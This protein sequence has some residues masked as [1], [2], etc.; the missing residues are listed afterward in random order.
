MPHC[1]IEHST[2]LD[3]SITPAV[4]MERVFQ[5]ALASALFDASVIKTRTLA[6]DYFQCGGEPVAFIHVSIRLL[7]GRDSNQKKNLSERVLAQLATLA[8]GHLSLT[9]EIIDID[10][11]SHAAIVQ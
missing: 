10:R 8:L 7:S 9:V 5:G 3:P 2:N 11:D 1:I 4:L 6:F